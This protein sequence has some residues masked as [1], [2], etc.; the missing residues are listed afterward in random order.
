MA[1]SHSPQIVMNGLA[2]CLDA[3]NV[4]SYNAGISTTTW[5]DLS[6]NAG[7][8]TL[9]NGPTYGSFNGGII[10][11]DGTNDFATFTSGPNLGITSST[12]T[13]TIDA[14]FKVN[15]FVSTGLSI[16]DTH[17][18]VAGSNA[19]GIETTGSNRIQYSARQHS[20]SNLINIYGPTISLYTYYNATV[21]RNGTTNTQLYVNAGLTTTYTGNVPLTTAAGIVTDSYISRWEDAN[22]P[23]SSISVSNIKIYNRALSAAEIQQNYNALG[24][25]FS[26]SGVVTNGLVLNL[27]TANPNSYP[28]SG[29]TWTDLSGNGNTGTLTNGP[30]FSSANGGSLVFDGT[31]DFIDFTSD[32][33]LLPTA[34]LT[35]SAWFKTTV[36][37]IWLVNKTSNV[38]TNGYV[39][40]SNGA[41]NMQFAV[42]GILVTTPSV[43]T[44]GAWIN[45]VGT[46]TPSTSLLMYQNGALVNTNTTSIP[47]SITNPSITLEIGRNVAGTDNW[48]GNL[49]QL[50]IY[51]RAL[52]AAEV[53]QNFNATRSRYGI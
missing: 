29:T 12:S 7:I 25:R 17:A 15:S 16:I 14:W 4:K 31:N 27:D 38:S 26:G 40:I 3:G 47:A 20:T 35:V 1:L 24:S 48:N 46:W 37:D 2:L 33:N 34:G 28:G 45:I 30:T 49:S 19:I 9:T 39:L 10:T 18:S 51:N 52:T 13:W 44:T 21:V 50:S 11:F 43:I 8:G 32:S 22:A 42:N 53:S 41:G 5:R 23:S 36:A 6:I